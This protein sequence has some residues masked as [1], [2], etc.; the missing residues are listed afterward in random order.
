M[1]RILII[2][3][4]LILMS[5]GGISRAYAVAAYPLPVRIIQPDG[6]T[7]TIRIH[8][9]EFLNWKTCGGRLVEQ[10]PEGYYYYATFGIDG[11]RLITTSRAIESALSQFSTDLVTDRPPQAAII[12]AAIRRESVMV[13]TMAAPSGTISTGEKRF[14]VILA[15]FA[16]LSFTPPDPQAHF[17]DML[18]LPGYNAYRATG[19]AYDYFY[20]NSSGQFNPQFD[21][22]GPVTLSGTVAY[23]GENDKDGEDV[24]PREMVVEAVR[25]ADQLLG[26]DFS[27]Y[28]IDGNGYIDNIFVYFAGY[29]EAEGGGDDTIWPHK[30]SI[31]NQLTVDGVKTGVYA[32]TSEFRGAPSGQDYAGIGTFCHEFGHVLGLPDFYDTDYGKNGDAAEPGPYSLMSS[33]NYNNQGRTPP[34]FSVM[35]RYLTGWISR[36]DILPLEKTGYYELDPVH[37]NTGYRSGT[38]TY[39]DYLPDGEYFLYETRLKSG[40]DRYLP[41]EGLLIYHVD[42]TPA[43]I[44]RWDNN[45]I[46]NFSN[47]PCYLIMEANP[48]GHKTF[49]G[50]TQK[51]EFTYA[52]DPGSLDWLNRPT[53]FDL[54]HI[55]LTGGRITCT[56]GTTSP[57]STYG[58]YTN[59]GSFQT[60]DVIVLRLSGTGPAIA[61]EQW[62]FN[63]VS[64]QAGSREL[65]TA[66]VHTIRA[67]LIFTDGSQETILQ[68]I[69][70]E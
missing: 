49:P 17:F 59:R 8:G 24:R 32:C 58:L 14:L 48:S 63:N 27:Q 31:Y 47:H 42:R 37:M 39:T 25:L 52:T 60:G 67:V 10:G 3:L 1:R 5:T 2:S 36:D 6:S 41:H 50:P 23:Y 65:L 21:V 20:E 54:Y 64:R 57:P 51:T 19:S 28:D 13:Q 30:W 45:A 38:V 22:V 62:Y 15:Q 55:S 53:G 33:G 18:N 34:Y 68:E 56:A 70:V 66:G 43:Y 40:W 4:M 29:N 46:N 61:S 69:Q 16:D 7:L 35:E 44:D 26:I 11:N 12:R 9:D